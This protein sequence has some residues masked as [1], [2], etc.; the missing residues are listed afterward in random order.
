MNT[1]ITNRETWLNT[2]T[3]KYIR[4]H[5]TEQGYT[6]PQNVRMS[7]SL[8]NSKKAIGLC[9]TNVVSADNTHEIM[10]SPKIADSAR[11]VD[12]LIHELIHAT[13]GVK[14]GHNAKFKK[15]ALSLGLEGK[16]TATI[17]SPELKAKILHWVAEIGEYPHAELYDA[18]QKKQG[19]RLLKCTCAECGYTV[20]LAKKWL[21]VAL[22]I[23]PNGMCESF[24]YEMQAET[25]DE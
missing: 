2:I 9:F 4:Q 15:V 20:R 6:I 12:I 17:A 19:T 5:F 14:E 23:C 1:P 21:D 22:P 16:M 24:N 13:I 3:D 7:C 18:N 25:N 11:V 8:T 10:V